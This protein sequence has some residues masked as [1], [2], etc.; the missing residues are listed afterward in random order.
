M[1]LGVTEKGNLYEKTN[2]GNALGAAVGGGIGLYKSYKH[3]PAIKEFC[4]TAIKDISKEQVADVLE[5]GADMIDGKK[6][7]AEAIKLEHMN[8][9]AKK[10]LTFVKNHP[11]GVGLAAGALA[12]I[13]VIGTCFN[14]LSNAINA[15]RMDKVAEAKEKANNPVEV[16]KKAVKSEDK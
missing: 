4:E 3:L 6:R 9:V 1:S 12:G 2:G 11:L 16:I 15:H 13:A 7:A 14:G 5:K 10:A 8:K